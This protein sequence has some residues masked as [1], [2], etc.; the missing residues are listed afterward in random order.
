A[1]QPPVKKGA[2]DRPECKEMEEYIPAYLLRGLIPAALLTA[3]D[4]W[5]DTG[6]S[7]R[8]TGYGQGEVSVELLPRA[9][10]LGVGLE[11]PF[12]C[13][14]EPAACARIT[15][16]LAGPDGELEPH[17]LLNLLSAPKGSPLHSMAMWASRLDDLSHV[18]AWGRVR[19]ADESKANWASAPLRIMQFPRLGLTFFVKEEEGGRVRRLVSA[20]FGNLTVPLAPVPEQVAKL[21]AGIPHA[22]ILCD[23]MQSLHVLVPQYLPLRP[24]IKG[25]PFTTE[26]V[27]ERLGKWGRNWSS[28]TKVTYFKYEVHVSKG[29][30]IAP[31]FASAL[32]LLLL[33]FLARDYEGVCSL[34]HAVGT[35]AELNEEE[36]QILKVLGL[37]DDAHPDAL[38]CR[39]LVTLAVL[40]SGAP[41]PW[42]YRQEFAWYVSK[43]SHISARSRMS[44]DQES[45]LLEECERLTSKFRVTEAQTKKLKGREKNIILEML[46][47]PERAKAAAASE[48]QKLQDLKNDIFS[49][50]RAEGL[51]CKEVEMQRLVSKIQ[52]R[53]HELPDW[54]AHGISN[55]QELLKAR[56]YK[57][58]QKDDKKK[59]EGQ[60]GQEGCEGQE[61]R[62][63]RSDF[64]A[65][66]TQG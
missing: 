1:R 14:D 40:R 37:V 2:W 10:I 47:D 3:Y 51:S 31:S 25:R 54:M 66:Q 12:D 39:C 5:Q 44:L 35:D 45:E 41:M 61:G 50:M 22:V 56:G 17:L 32:Y 15:M 46:L 23:E 43:M 65:T 49:A 16:D 19:A 9:T 8:L 53:E 60:K 63:G 20:D 24:T 48:M 34:V 26:I 33:R 36:A 30:L 59:Q 28:K 42:D 58:N 18:L 4:F 21:L 64:E 7:Y 38:A 13:T 62:D 29:F 27:F 57:V 52:Q 11:G 6:E 55:R